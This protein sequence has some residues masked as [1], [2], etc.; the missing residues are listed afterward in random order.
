MEWVR[1]YKV[2]WLASSGVSL[3]KALL[4]SI[5]IHALVLA[6]RF[7]P[8]K[9]TGPVSA[10]LEVI[11]VNAQSK[12]TPKDAKLLAQVALEGGGQADAG[13][14]TTTPT[15]SNDTVNQRELKAAQDRLGK[16][17]QMQRELESGGLRSQAGEQESPSRQ[18]ASNAA[19]SKEP[20]LDPKSQRALEIQRLQAQ[21]A[22]NI[23]SYNERPR[24]HFFSPQTSPYDFA[25]YE[26]GWRSRVEQIGNSNYPEELRGKIY[27]Q[28]RLTV[29]IKADGTIDNVEIDRSSGSTVL[30]RAA[31]KLLRMAAPFAPFPSELRQK[32][33]ILAITRTWVFSKDTMKT[34]F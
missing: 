1:H 27:G 21:I 19:D 8:P 10:P 34:Q 18:K 9:P 23:K 16:L 31:V 14:A 7:V 33:D 17:E 4:V 15:D 30:D 20:G 13:R 3:Q 32:A 6:V 25:I 26:E 29:Y 5:V 24:K 28:L 12:N 11:L 2:R 22:E